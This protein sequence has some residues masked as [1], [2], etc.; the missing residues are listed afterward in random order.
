[1]MQYLPTSRP[2]AL[3]SVLRDRVMLLFY[4]NYKL[5]VSTTKFLNMT[6]LLRDKIRIILLTVIYKVAH[7]SYTGARINGP[8]PSLKGNFP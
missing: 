3:C 4:G 5:Q 1:M 7:D 2:V 8:I 6:N